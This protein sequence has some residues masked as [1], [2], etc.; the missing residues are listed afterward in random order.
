MPD[1]LKLTDHAIKS[2]LELKKSYDFNFK[3]TESSLLLN[4]NRPGND[5]KDINKLI[6]D[7]CLEKEKIDVV[8]YLLKNYN[9]DLKN[10]TCTQT[11]FIEKEYEP[12]SP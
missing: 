7:Y 4:L 3:L 6:N 10:S 2:L 5:L 9:S 11:N 1:S 8:N 12:A